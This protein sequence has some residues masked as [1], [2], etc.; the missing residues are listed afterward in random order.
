MVRKCQE[1]G[2]CASKGIKKIAGEIS[3]EDA[4][5]FAAT[6]R[7]GLPVHKSFKEWLQNRQID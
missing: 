7:K 1:T 2:D 4:H 6:P 3:P 5:D